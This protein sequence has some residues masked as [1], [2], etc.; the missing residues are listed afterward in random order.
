MSSR[1]FYVFTFCLLGA[2]LLA[3]PLA[4][5]TSLQQGLSAN[6]LRDLRQEKTVYVAQ[7]VEGVA[8]PRAIV[9]RYVPG[10]SSKEVMAVFSSYDSA[11]KFVPNVV[12]SKVVK[13]YSPWDKDVEYEL[14]IPF[15]PNEEYTAR[16][17]L[18]V[19]DQGRQIQAAW[20]ADDARFFKSSVGN[21][22]VQEWESGCLMRY[23]NLVNPGT[24]IASVLRGSARRQIIATVE[25]IANRAAALKK[26]NPALLQ[27]KVRALESALAG[28][29]GGSR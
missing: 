19:M 2:T 21:L 10:V 25:A 24:Q 27:Q 26:Q 20:T 11:S 8:W 3:P 15:F 22:V 18:S 29:P 23:T 28:S 1:P 7:D 14:R 13:E 16:N 9:Y 5:A 4:S 6:Q 17:V 12:S